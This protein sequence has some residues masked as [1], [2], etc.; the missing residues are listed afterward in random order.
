MASLNVM[1]GLPGS[2]KSTFIK[3]HMNT[4]T[5]VWVSRDAI[6]FSLLNDTDEYFAKETMVKNI[7]F[8]MINHYLNE[9]KN[10][11]MDATHLSIASRDKALNRVTA[12]RDEMNAFFFTT[13]MEYCIERNDKR[14]GRER[15]P[16]GHINRMAYQ[17]EPPVPYEG[18]DKIYF[19]DENGDITRIKEKNI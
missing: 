10:V 18:F 1:I 8:S 17:L 6:R 3:N 14:E 12:A 13:P 16:K 5:D 7:F 19:I 4:E 2:G 9:G 15:V 11:W